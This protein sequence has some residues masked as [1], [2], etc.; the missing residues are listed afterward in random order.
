M[1]QESSNCFENQIDELSFIISHNMRSLYRVAIRRVGNDADAQDALQDAFLSAYIH[2]H[3]FRAKAKMSTW[4][5][6]IVINSSLAVVRKRLRRKYMV[7]VH[8]EQDGPPCERIV[9]GRPDPEEV[10]QRGQAAH[11]LDGF[12]EQLSP[13]LRRTFQLREV[14]C[15]S[16][17]ETARIL[18]VSE[19]VV[20]SRLSRA[21]SKLKLYLDESKMRDSPHNVS[22][23]PWRG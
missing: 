1:T 13:I 6:T 22:K 10:Y 16:T 14:D 5:T 9:D 7:E 12:V 20:K 8:S 2:L 23:Q 19:N 15:L 11:R 17:Y 3:Q 18:D 4:L 21:R